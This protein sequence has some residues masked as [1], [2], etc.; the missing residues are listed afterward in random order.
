MAHPRL[1]MKDFVFV[2]AD[3][4]IAWY[5][6]QLQPKHSESKRIKLEAFN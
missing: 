1:S 2:T 4:V 6:L 5:E 3:T